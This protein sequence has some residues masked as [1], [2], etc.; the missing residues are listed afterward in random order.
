MGPSS[1]GS[2]SGNPEAN[3]ERNRQS[4]AELAAELHRDHLASKLAHTQ[5]APAQEADTPKR[6]PWW[7]R[8][9]HRGQLPS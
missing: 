3:A 9:F 1:S 4:Q 8:I 5:H 2:G 7:K 6:V